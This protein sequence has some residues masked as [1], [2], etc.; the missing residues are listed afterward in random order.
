MSFVLDASVACALPL[1]TLD[2]QLG[3]AARRE[4]IDV[5]GAEPD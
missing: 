5:L 2:R 1:A 3:K 4:A